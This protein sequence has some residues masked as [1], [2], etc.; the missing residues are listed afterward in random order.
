MIKLGVLSGGISG[1]RYLSLESGEHIIKTL[2]STGK[3]EL[4]RIDWELPAK[5]CMYAVNGVEKCE[6]KS[7]EELLSKGELQGIHFNVLFNA[8]HGHEEADG[9]IGA[10]LELIK[11]ERGIAFAGNGLY[12]SFVGM[13]KQITNEVLKSA[14]LPVINGFLVRNQNEKIKNTDLESLRFPCIAKPVSSGSSLGISIAHSKEE[15]EKAIKSAKKKDFPYLIQ[16]FIHGKEYAVG[17]LGS[18]NQVRTLTPV[19]VQYSGEYF[20]AVC[21]ETGA[22]QMVEAELPFEIEKKLSD[23]ALKAHTLLR[24]TAI[25]R[26]DFIIQPDG[27]IWILEINTHPG[28][29][30]HSIIP[31]QLEYSGIKFGKFIEEIIGV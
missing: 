7:L 6:A 2:N 14:G 22:Y 26:T 16:P 21:K 17:V 11:N 5:W 18:G 25:T 29:S 12:T 31:A 23:Y 1:E 24:A 30:E 27:K 13:D 9:H 10:V 20:D 4:Y 19:E 28:L 15:L 8:F 3:Y